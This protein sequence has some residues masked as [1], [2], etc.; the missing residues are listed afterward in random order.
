MTTATETDRRITGES[1]AVTLPKAPREDTPPKQWPIWALKLRQDYEAEIS[2][3]KREKHELEMT[4][5]DTDKARR[6][7]DAQ[8]TALALYGETEEVK[9]LTRRLEYIL[10]NA[11]DIG[12]QGCALVAQISIAQGLDPTPGSDHLY[13]WTK[14]EGANKQLI[15]TIGYKGL[16]YLGRQQVHFTHLT[17]AMTADERQEHSLSA[18]QLGYITELYEIEKAQQCMAAGVPYFP[19]IGMAIWAAVITHHKKGGETWKEYNDPPT[20]RDG[21]WVCRKNSLK[22]ALRQITSTGVRIKAA[23]DAA[24]IQQAAEWR[25]TLPTPAEMTEHDLITAG[26]IPASDDGDA[27]EGI[28]DGAFSEKEDD[29]TPPNAP[30]PAAAVLPLEPPTPPSESTDEPKK[31]AKCHERPAVSTPVGDDYCGL[32]ANRIADEQAKES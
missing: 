10:P 3:L 24:F 13:V 12:P 29:P 21:V 17:R 1:P 20:G 5:V 9:S 30:L 2:R 31:C 27:D 23:L 4:M 14:G 18:D 25:V 6:Q 7:A 16:L 32:C 28:I 22:D 8:N 15:V 26:V 19:I 11:K